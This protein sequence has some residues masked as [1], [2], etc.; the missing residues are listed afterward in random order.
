MEEFLQFIRDYKWRIV[1]IVGGIVFTI[2]IFTI[3][4]W[5]TLL[6]ALIVGV[7]YLIGYL[8]DQGGREAVSQFISDIFGKKS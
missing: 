2:L 1:G 3:N 4:L 5:R 7:C 8:L 6:L